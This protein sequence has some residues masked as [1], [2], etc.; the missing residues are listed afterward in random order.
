MKALIISI[1]ALTAMSATAKTWTLDECIDFAIENNIRVKNTRIQQL[2]GEQEVVEAKDRF[3]PQLSGYGSQ[4][5]NFGRGLTADNTYANRNTSSFSVGANLSLPIFQGLSAIRTLDYSKANLKAL[6]EQT[7]SAK[8][9]VALNVI[10]QYL[11]ALYASEILQVAR[12]NLGI[13]QREFERRQELFN[14]GKVAELDVYEA[15]AQVSRDELSVVNAANDSITARLDLSQLLNLPSAE[16]FQIEPIA[17]ELLPLSSP[18]EVFA[19]AMEINHGILAQKRS[20]EAAEKNISVAKSGYI[21]TL[22]FNA[23]LGTNYYK[24]SGFPNEGF[25]PQMR[26]NFSKTIGFSLSVPL[27]DGFGTRNRIRRAKLQTETARLQLDDSR[28][29]LYKNIQT[30]YTQALGAAK[31]Q[32]SAQ[33]AVE[34]SR[35]AFEAM[36]LKYEN[37]RANG[38]ELEKAQ[39]D[40]TSALA[41]SVQAKYENTLRRRILEF[42]RTGRN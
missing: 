37:G 4:S 10:A 29:Q 17:D 36:Q 7:E 2:Q 9:D 23:G 21:P 20:I 42:Y 14:A 16:D 26:H 34:S 38:T 41:E 5:F 22:S 13:S 28:L 40:Y 12:I 25:G 32:E 6:L 27:F 3:L 24:T 1:A 11:Q 15:R 35:A 33:T 18:D 39:S 19:S 8:D 30:A 31:K